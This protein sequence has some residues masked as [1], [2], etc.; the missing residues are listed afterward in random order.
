[1]KA[2]Y[3]KFYTKFPKSL[4]KKFEYIAVDDHKL[5]VVNFL[6]LFLLPSLYCNGWIDLIKIC[7]YLIPLF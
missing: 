2:K 4:I 5:F 1:M 6:I 3:E 7:F